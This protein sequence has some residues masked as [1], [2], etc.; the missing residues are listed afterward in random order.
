M[1][2]VVSYFVKF[3]PVTRNFSSRSGSSTCLMLE[4]LC[5]IRVNQYHI[6]GLPEEFMTCLQKQL[7]PGH[8]NFWN[9]NKFGVNKISDKFAT[10]FAQVSLYRSYISFAKIRPK[11]EKNYAP[12]EILLSSER[13]YGSRMMG[14]RPWICLVLIF[15]GIMNTLWILL[16]FIPRVISGHYY[17]TE[18]SKTRQYRI[19][20]FLLVSRTFPAGFP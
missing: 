3:S 6:W 13:G 17:L 20:P 12:I 10:S 9:E 11:F 4:K 15:F 7:I 2:V 1:Q 5:Q 18:V 8:L 14:C 19:P 16:F